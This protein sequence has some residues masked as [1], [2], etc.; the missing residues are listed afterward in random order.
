[1]AVIGER[2]VFV[3]V[4]VLQPAVPYLRRGQHSGIVL[5]QQILVQVFDIGIVIGTPVAVLA[6]EYPVYGV[7]QGTWLPG[8]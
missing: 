7:T 6:L 3:R 8:T 1:M 2:G 5:D 4:D